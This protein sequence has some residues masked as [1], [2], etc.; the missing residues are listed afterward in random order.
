MP[1]RNG[2]AL[3]GF[4][5]GRRPTYSGTFSQPTGYPLLRGRRIVRTLGESQIILK[6]RRLQHLTAYQLADW[7]SALGTYHERPTI[8]LSAAVT[9]SQRKLAT[10]RESFEGFAGGLP[11]SRALQFVANR[12]TSCRANSC[13]RFEREN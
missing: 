4:G 7:G 5:A 12:A 3:A 8:R 9:A 10:R 13:A 11:L 1:P 2:T 6:R